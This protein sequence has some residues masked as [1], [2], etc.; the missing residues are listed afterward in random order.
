[1]KRSSRPVLKVTTGGTGVAAHAGSRLLA[2]MADVLGLTEGLSAAMAPTRQ[3]RSAHDPGRVL[4]DLAV[5]AAD[6]GTS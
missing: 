3:R 2:D 1:M 5:M 6:G 4:V